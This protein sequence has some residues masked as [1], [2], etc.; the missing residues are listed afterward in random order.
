[1]QG[2]R[3]QRHK[4]ADYGVPVEKAGVGLGTP[5]G[6]ERQIEVVVWTNRNAANNIRKGRSKEDSEQR[7]GEE[8]ESIKEAAPEGFMHMHAELYTETPQNEQPQHNHERHV[9]AAEGGGVEK[10]KSEEEGSTGGQQPDLIA[11]PY[12]PDGAQ[13]VLALLF[14]TR[15]EGKDDADTQIETV[16]NDVS[17]EH[18][19][20]D[21]EPECAHVPSS[22]AVVRQCPEP[23]SPTGLGPF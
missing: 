12:R 8:E 4:A 2:E 13:S 15:N 6:P 18:D 19:G 9:K 14:G 20:H 5:V 10:G 1:M 23:G 3:E 11:V 21:P 17:R 22:Y 16:E 7:T